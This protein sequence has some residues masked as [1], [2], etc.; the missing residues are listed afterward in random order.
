MNSK[1]IV[2]NWDSE[3]HN[4]SKEMVPK[5]QQKLKIDSLKYES[6]LKKLY[7][8]YILHSFIVDEKLSNKP[9]SAIM[10]FWGKSAH[11]VLGLYN[12][13]KSGL[14]SEAAILLRNVFELYVNVKLILEQ[15]VDER[16]KLWDDFRFII[17]WNNYQLNL[18]LLS[19]GI[20]SLEQFEKTFTTELIKK[21]EYNYEKVKE[22]YHPKYPHHWAWKIFKDKYKGRNPNL[23]K[24]CDH[25]NLQFDYVK[26]Y[27]SLSTIVHS[28]PHMSNLISYGQNISIAPIFSEKISTLIKLSVDYSCELIYSI[29]EHLDKKLGDELNLYLS[30]FKY[31]VFYDL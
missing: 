6:I 1:N 28:T 24:I 9:Y 4:Y 2:K 21:I 19:K 12:C 7:D 20:I 11:S 3:L 18:N 13:L 8:L 27:S 31:N 16:V 22:N 5:F 15:D 30:Y 17:E 14:A 26:I 25:L 23:K 29:T 10:L